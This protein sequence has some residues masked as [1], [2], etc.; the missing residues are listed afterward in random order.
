MNDP[1]VET[2]HYG[3]GAFFPVIVLDPRPRWARPVPPALPTLAPA[4]PA[5]I[6]A[7]RWAGAER[8]LAHAEQLLLQAVRDA[9]AEAHIGQLDLYR[10]GLPPSVVLI[11]LPPNALIGP[12]SD[13]PG[14]GH[15]GPNQEPRSPIASH[16][17][18]SGFRPNGSL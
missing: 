16:R 18:P 12:W 10:A 4:G 14:I 17:Q 8:D 11:T 2:G 13:R 6:L 7:V 9:P 1:T 15:L 3:I 5:D